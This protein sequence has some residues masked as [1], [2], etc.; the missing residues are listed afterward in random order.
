MAGSL[1]ESRRLAKMLASAD[2]RRGAA[3]RKKG[4]INQHRR[5]K[6]FLRAGK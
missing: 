2:D 6:G 4:R 5:A 3:R 1:R